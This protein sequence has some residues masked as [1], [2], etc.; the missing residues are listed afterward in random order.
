MASASG[1]LAS[2][3]ELWKGPGVTLR[4]VDERRMGKS[5]L[6][7]LP[8]EQGYWTISHG[9][10]VNL[11]QES[12]VQRTMYPDQFTA[13]GAWKD[14]SFEKRGPRSERVCH[15][16]LWPV[17]GDVRSIPTWNRHA[18]VPVGD[19]TRSA[20]PGYRGYIPG[21][22]AETVF[23]ESFRVANAVSL[24]MRP[25][26][27]GKAQVVPE[28]PVPYVDL[29]LGTRS[30]R[31]IKSESDLKHSVFYADEPRRSELLAS[32]YTSLTNLHKDHEIP[33][34]MTR[35]FSSPQL[36]EA[37][38]GYT[39]FVHGRVAEAAHLDWRHPQRDMECTAIPNTYG[40]ALSGWSKFVPGKVSETVHASNGMTNSFKSM[41]T[42]RY[43]EKHEAAVPQ[44]PAA[45]S[46][47][48]RSA[49]LASHQ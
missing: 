29:P 37:I 4:F 40:S 31:T 44:Y 41:Q 10:G 1:A 13:G 2:T 43:F 15:P 23:G 30:L 24:E 28:P 17:P 27:M 11:P 20:L 39:G 12:N 18:E 42:R 34:A 16:S 45:I 21:K 9:A 48:A 22:K 19:F 47:L 14:S 49:P 38:P 33:P 5:T 8:P 25:P 26:G 3:G 36:C 6:G 32:G 35:T 7:K 46:D